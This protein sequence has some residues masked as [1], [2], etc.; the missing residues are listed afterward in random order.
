[1]QKLDYT[2]IHMY[3]RVACNVTRSSLFVMEAGNYTRVE[4]CSQMLFHLYITTCTTSMARS[5]VWGGWGYYVVVH[6]LF[7]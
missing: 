6:L 1:M 7:L 2:H 4:S 3:N 5:T